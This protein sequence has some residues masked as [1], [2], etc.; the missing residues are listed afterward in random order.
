MMVNT[1]LL[2]ARHPMRYLPRNSRIYLAEDG[3]TEI[4]GPGYEDKRPWYVTFVDPFDLVGMCKGRNMQRR[5][6]DTHEAGRMEVPKE[7]GDVEK[8][9]GTAVVNG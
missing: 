7:G 6:W 1:F 3:K 2:N 9:K 5:F 4:E 8:G